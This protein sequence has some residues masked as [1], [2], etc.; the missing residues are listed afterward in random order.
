MNHHPGAMSANERSFLLSSLEAGVRVDSRQPL[1]SRLLTLAFRHD[2]NAVELTLGET[3]V[4]ATATAELVEPFADRPT[5]G[6]L[7]FAVDFSPMASPAFEPGRPSEAAIEL[8]RLLDRTLRKSQAIDVEALCVIAGK[9][10]WSVRCDATVLDHRGN[11][12]DAVALATLCALKHLRLPAV[13]ISGAGDESIARVLPTDQ[14]DPT[15]LVFHHYPIAVSYAFFRPTESGSILSALDPTD[16]EERVMLG[17]LTAV[18]NQH[19]ELCSLDKAGGLPLPSEMLLESVQHASTVA[20]QR[21]SLME[22]ASKAQAER[23][24][25]AAEVLRKTGRKQQREVGE[26]SI[27]STGEQDV[28]N[29]SSRTKRKS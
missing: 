14:E 17:S 4:L 8:M 9:R 19:K 28:N 27:V 2:S 22:A 16:R 5:E 24:A 7:H 12:T 13:S 15:H 21:L 18:V 1:D 3:K 11:L 10:V 26:V 20:A 23:Q 6:V 25:I 29:V